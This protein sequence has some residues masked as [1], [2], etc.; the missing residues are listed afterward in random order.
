VTLTATPDPGSTFAGWSGGGC[1]GT[2]SCKVTISREQTIVALF[3]RGP[4]LSALAVVPRVFV[5]TGRLVKGHCV[6][7]THANR[8]HRRCARAITLRISYQL[9]A[10]ARVMIT[11]ARVLPGRRAAGH[12]V[13][14]TRGNRQH[15]R[16]VRLVAVP[17]A[18]TANSTAG[19]N[20]VTFHGRIGGH[21]LTAGHYQLKAS[22]TAN[23]HAG[24]SR[25]ITLTIT[26]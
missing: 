10:P 23:G 20:S 22:P 11:I 5:L 17:G 16:C 3:V 9:T 6:V 7:A 8:R 25:T 14:P 19:A 4:L 21:R 12:C 18:L 13:K 26:R 15:H 24:S 2:R 1:S